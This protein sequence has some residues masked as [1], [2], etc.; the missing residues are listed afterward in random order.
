MIGTIEV[1]PDVCAALGKTA[2]EIKGMSLRAL[3]EL[4]YEKGLRIHV[5]PFALR[6]E[7]NADNAD[8]TFVM[9]RTEEQK[10]A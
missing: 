4:A 7:T 2:E 10:Q 8:L 6:D 9:V 1:K 3:A 5:L